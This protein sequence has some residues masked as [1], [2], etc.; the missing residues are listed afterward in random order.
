MLGSLVSGCGTNTLLHSLTWKTSY[1]MVQMYLVCSL[2]LVSHLFLLI[3]VFSLTHP[4]EISRL[5]F[6]T[7]VINIQHSYCL[8]CPSKES[9]EYMDRLLEIIHYKQY[10]WS[11]VW[12]PTSLDSLWACKQGSQ[13]SIIAQL[14]SLSL[15]QSRCIPS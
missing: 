13:N 7:T 9:Y 14:L 11:F 4:N 12:G 15:G 5:Y 2:P 10:L 6:S 1:A 8:F 3:G